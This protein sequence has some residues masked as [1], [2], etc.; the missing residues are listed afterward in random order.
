M[1]WWHDEPLIISAVQ[2]KFEDDDSWTLNEYVAKSGFNTEQLLHLTGKGH[3]AYYDEETHGARLDEYLKQSRKLGIREII[4][5]NT[6]CLTPEVVKQHP[7]WQQLKIDGKPIEAYTIYSL[8]CING[9][10]FDRFAKNISDLCHH[11]ID[12]IFLDGPVM[13]EEGC[14]CD[15]CKSQF[16]NKFGKSIYEGTRIEMQSMRVDSVT[17]FIIK[18]NKIVKSINSEI[19]LYLNNSALRADITGSNSRK[20]EPYVDMIGA[21]G[22]FVRADNKTSLW[23]V[24]SKVKHMETVAKGKPMVTFIAGNQS[25][26]AYYMHNAAETRV[27]YAQTYANGANAWYGLHGSAS[28]FMDSPGSKAAIEFNEFIQF[29]KEIFSKSQSCA[30]VGL[31]WSQDSANNYSSTVE[32]SDFTGEKSTGFKDRGD[33]YT[34]LMSFYDIL[35]R[36]HIQFDIVD[37]VNVLEGLGKYQLIFIPDCACMSDEAAA[38]ITSYVKSGGNICSTFCSGFY[39]ADGTFAKTPKLAVVQGILKAERI[40]KYPNTGTAYQ[41]LGKCSWMF[42]NLSADLLPGSLLSVKCVPADGAESVST[43]LVPM[44]SV[45]T[46]LPIDGFPGIILNRYGNGNSVYMTGTFGITYADR[47]HT[48]YAG[49]V[50]NIV[51]HY[52]KPML[53]CDCPGLVE[54]VLRRQQGRYLLHFINITGEMNRPIKKLVPL[55]NLKITLHLQETILQQPITIRGAKLEEI[56]S[57][58]G[59]ICFS[60]SSLIDYEVVAIPIAQESIT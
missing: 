39:N 19:L 7:D 16:Y 9:G 15:A 44:S 23:S 25:G 31:M 37:E 8:N 3:M 34:E 51:A 6:H 38:A 5:Y 47:A 20:V 59:C 12:G 1:S 29:N 13:R 18:T 28:Q 60:L 26:L 55:T 48:D 57:S 42:D 30:K 27:L 54:I 33:H 4:Y 24:S 46:G 14:Y 40:V 50:E 41:Q 35:T 21:E 22:G 2:C 53:E 52:S 49:M 43:S 58:E 56:Q 45:Y 36:A 32:Q 11:D 10:W 17:E